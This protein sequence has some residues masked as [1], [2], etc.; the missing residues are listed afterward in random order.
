MKRKLFLFAGILFTGLGFLGAVLPLMPATPFLLV[1]AYFFSKSSDRLL[2]WLLTNKVCGSYIRNYREQ[3]GM[4]L[5]DKVTTIALIWGSI[6]AS[7][8]WMTDKWPVR[9]VMFVTALIV[10]TYIV[11]LKVLHKSHEEKCLITRK[12]RTL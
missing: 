9:A 12:E 4:E 10:T 2:N 1:A 7:S 6:L 8:I 5:N 3:R 11:Q